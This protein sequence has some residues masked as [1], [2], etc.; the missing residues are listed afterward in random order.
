MQ[1]EPEAKKLIEQLTFVLQNKKLQLDSFF[2]HFLQNSLNA[3]TCDDSRGFRCDPIVLAWAE[4][5][6]FRGGA[7][8]LSLL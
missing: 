7:G 3:L 2:H 1:T 4:S 6:R 8:I 5:L